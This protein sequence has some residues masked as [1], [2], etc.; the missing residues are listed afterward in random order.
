M[1][2]SLIILSSVLVVQVVLALALSVH[3]TAVDALPPGQAL[4]NF[5]PAKVDRVSIAS[6]GKATL[7][8]VKNG[9]GWNMPQH[10]DFP[11]SQPKVESFL[12]GLAG[13]KPRLPIATSRAARARFKVGA[14]HYAHRITLQSN[15]HTVASVFLGE[16]D[17]ARRSY[18]RVAGRPAI[19]EV[20]LGAYQANADADVWGNP[21]Y[22]HLKTSD[23]T[24]LQLPQVSLERS[25][26]A[27]RVPKLAAGKQVDAARSAALVADLANLSYDAVLGDQDQPA[28]GQAKPALRVS[29]TLK[30]GSKITYVFSKPAKGDDYVLKTSAHPFYFKI[31]AY[32]VTPLLGVTP[33]KLAQRKAPAK[34]SHKAAA[35]SKS[36]TS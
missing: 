3:G 27:W 32:A 22:L 20:A 24:R 4:L 18:A 15:G 25:K 19:Y 33:A 35:P 9:H 26:H 34:T 10:F 14:K 7:V 5:D 21:D 23:I 11:A 8:L 30:S 28:Y 31:P 1:Q 2:R 36:S 29:A 12:R 13:L 6:P 17:G 16:A